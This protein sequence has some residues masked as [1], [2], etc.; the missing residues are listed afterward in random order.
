MPFC[1][2]DGHDLHQANLSPGGKTA[3]L[4]CQRQGQQRGLIRIESTWRAR[5][6]RHLYSLDASR[7]LS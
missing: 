2:L 5:P 7:I 3:V 6:V 1:V 4:L